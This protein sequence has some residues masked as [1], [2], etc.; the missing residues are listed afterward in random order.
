M[1]MLRNFSIMNNKAELDIVLVNPPT[2][3]EQ[4][5]GLLSG[6]GAYRPP[7]N[8]LNLGVSLI[9]K[10]YSVEIIDG[11]VL[12]GG[13]QNI[14]KKIKNL[15]P[16]Y[17]GIT[18]MTAFIH[19]AAFIASE[20]HRFLPD[21]LVIIGGIHITTLPE[22]TMRSFPDFDIGILGEG[23]ITLIELL[24]AL[25]HKK[26][27]FDIN[28]LI[29]RD[30]KKEFI[31]TGKRELIKNLDI[32]PLPAWQL[33]PDYIKTYQ[34]TSS[35]RT[36]LPSAYIVTSR[37]CPFACTFCNNSVHGR[38]FRSYSVDYLMKIVDYMIEVY[39]IKDLTIYDE[40]LALDKKRITEF[41]DRL[42]KENYDL[43]WSCDARADSVDADL[44][45]LMYDAGC[46][47]IW[48]GMESGNEKI[49]KRYNKGLKL[50]HLKT[51]ALLTIK[52]GIKSCGSFIIG[53]PEE[54]PDTIRDT[55]RFA[56]KSKLTHFIPFYYTPVPGTIDY[57]GIKD[58]G[59]VNLNYE[60]ATMSKPTFAPWGMTFQQVEKWYCISLLSFYLR[61]QIIFR[62]I[63]EMGFTDLI[64]LCISV[65]RNILSKL[66]IVIK[67][68][69][70]KRV[71][72]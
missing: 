59:T 22:K 2:T 53:G 65:I 56:K 4:E 27:I 21:I 31:L 42:I 20:I 72:T 16:K 8:L 41:C 67:V 45:K 5:F 71:K 47:S 13:V 1:N 49:L 29:Y 44:L 69:L 39:N 7:L 6:A 37:G 46:R 58:F 28:G 35:R 57:P 40:N 3:T 19:I 18:S 60:D 66:F 14:I 48:Y 50:E 55:I 64:K 51:A 38:S 43:T 25:K 30:K 61:P 17:V 11:P 36:R 15:N 9:Q 62:L 33:L 54:T 10:G 34:P 68:L 70:L 24:D 26:S 52:Q 12:S 32:L 63:R 23:E